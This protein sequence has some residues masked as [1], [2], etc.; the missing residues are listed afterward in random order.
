M[1]KIPC[2]NLLRKLKTFE[3]RVNFA[4]E[5]GKKLNII[6]RVYFTE[7]KGLRCQILFEFPKRRKKSNLIVYN[8]SAL[9]HRKIWGF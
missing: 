4:R 7:G 9:T 2:S 1:E 3:D 5:L 8:F 6:F